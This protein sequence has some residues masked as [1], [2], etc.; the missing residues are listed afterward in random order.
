MIT[1]ESVNQWLQDYVSAWKS[2]DKEAIGALFSENATYQYNPY[3]EGDD[4]LRGRD[5]IIA[6]W[7]ENAD[8]PNSWQ[9]AY[10]VVAVDG[11][12]A[13]AQGRTQ[14]F[15]ADGKTIRREFDNIFVMRF[16]DKGQCYEFCE[17]FMEPRGQ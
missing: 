13:V 16:D 1:R 6:N 5:V 8:A 2:Y 12:V 15:Q 10:K 17:W 11:N 7:L 9:A 14:Y 3:D 4:V